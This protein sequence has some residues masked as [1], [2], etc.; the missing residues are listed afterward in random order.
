MEGD[1]DIGRCIMAA[2]DL[3]AH[4][5]PDGRMIDVGFVLDTPVSDSGC[6]GCGRL[7]HE[8]T[9]QV[10]IGVTVFDLPRLLCTNCTLGKV[11]DAMVLF[12]E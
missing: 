8:D 3:Y 10:H 9:A 12:P 6:I 2:S 11:E 1:D 7:L 5:N 4:N